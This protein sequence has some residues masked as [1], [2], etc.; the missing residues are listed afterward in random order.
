MELF[1]DEVWLPVKGYE[2]LYEISNYGRVKSLPKI[3][4]RALSEEKLLKTRITNGYV[5]VGL[6]K[7]GKL[8]NASVH[9]LIAQA[10]IPNPECK[11]Q[12]NHIDGNKQNNS[13]NNLEWCT[14]SENT[15]HAY[16]KGLKTRE[17]CARYGKRRP[18]SDVEK[19]YISAKTKEAMY[20]PEVQEKL[21]HKRKAVS[22]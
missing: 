20:R 4:G 8:F 17:S 3:R 22:V 2:G 14:A 5:M 12:I 16:A 19:A 21:H 15:I 9:R 6:R 10:F 11:P 18:L 1:K 13:V 7:N